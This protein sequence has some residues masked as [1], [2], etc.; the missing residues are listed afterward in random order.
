MLTSTHKSQFLERGFTRIAGAVDAQDVAEAATRV[1]GV[2]S[3]SG[4]RRAHPDTWRQDKP[5]GL[6]NVAGDASYHRVFGKPASAVLDTLLGA[7]LW[8]SPEHWGQ[9]V[10]SLPTDTT[11]VVPHQAWHLDLPMELGNTE[12]PGVQ[13]F[14]CLEDISERCGAT[15]VAAGTHRLVAEEVSANGF[16]EKRAS[17]VLRNRLSKKSDWF[18]QLIGFKDAG[19][20]DDRFLLRPYSECQVT[21]QVHELTGNKGDMIL[22]HPYLFHAPAPNIGPAIRMA[23]TQRI[24]A[25]K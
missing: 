15:V 2:L 19:E 14:V 18:R 23:A 16:P 3:K 10:L 13:L 24:Y 22:M 1:W 8:N 20:R 25:S 5:K 11:W 6:Q 4:I 7:G 17:A 21:L 12:L 9:L